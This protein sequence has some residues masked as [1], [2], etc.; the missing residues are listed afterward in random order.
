[1][2]RILSIILASVMLFAVVPFVS[3]ANK[4]HFRILFI[5]NSYSEDATD[6]FTYPDGRVYEGY[7]TFY[8]MMKT[9]LGDGVE[10]EV[11]L[12]MSGGKP[13]SW[14]AAT[15]DGG[16]ENYEFRVVGD[17]TD[18]LWQNVPDVKTTAGALSYDSWDA[19]V[20]QPYGLEI[21]KG[22]SYGE[23][24]TRKFNLIE[25]ST[26]FMLDYVGE[27]V[28]DAR[29]Y[30]Y[31]I[32]S[33]S[34]KTEYFAGLEKF[35]KIRYFTE[36]A[37][38]LTG[39]KT[40]KGFAAVVPVGTAIQNARS[41]FLSLHYAVDPSGAVNFDTDPVTGLQR[42]EL[43]VSYS[44]GRY[45]AALTFVE[46]LVPENERRGDPLAVEIRRPEGAQP[47]PDEYKETAQAAVTEA[48][49]S[50]GNESED[51]FASVDLTAY[52]DDPADIEAESLASS[53]R[54]VYLPSDGDTEKDI[55]Q[56]LKAELPDGAVIETDVG[57][58]VRDGDTGS[59]AV[60][61]TYGYKSA[62][63]T[64]PLRF[65]D[66]THVWELETDGYVHGAGKYGEIYKCTICGKEKEKIIKGD[67]CPSRDFPDVPVYGNWAHEGID[68]CIKCKL[69]NGVSEARFNPG[70]TTTRAM[71]VTVLWRYAGEPESSA[72]VPFKDLKA[73]W[74]RDA[75]RWAFENSVVNGTS[76]TTFSPDDPLTREQIAT[77]L[78][79]FT[80]GLDGSDGADL[81]GFTDAGKISGYAKDAMAWAFAAG[82]INGVATPTGTVLDPRGNATRAQ[83]AAI[84][85]RYLTK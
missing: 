40:G 73:D 53:P 26:S 82:L 48:L 59:V 52:K 19:V 47:L 3:A 17:K 31:L 64:V 30:L 24:S 79:R 11:A 7:S 81:S 74:Y 54:D 12:A 65:I 22:Y 46:T 9:V 4:G 57:S 71:L 16:L 28:P 37:S 27:R 35:N 61:L 39:E 44:I 38:H 34:Q 76:G 1:M 70:G 20:L 41:T 55:S 85:F 32:I 60:T 13:M 21:E 62:A 84:L 14:H 45:I 33:K 6:G 63:A 2:K 5:G 51:K 43:H 18:G 75:V 50:V 72:K 56:A 36:I 25:E 83:V 8:N 58:L 23:T 42:D 29:I 68:F 10:L 78:F 15:A 80:G 66:H 49:E 77:I 69:M 67:P